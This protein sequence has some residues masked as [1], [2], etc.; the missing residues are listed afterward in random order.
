M[1]VLL[2]VLL[3][4]RFLACRRYK[5][6]GRG[7]AFL[8][9]GRACVILTCCCCCPCFS[10]PGAYKGRGRGNVFLNDLCDADVLVHV[11]DASGTTDSEGAGA[12]PGEGADPRQEVL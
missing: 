1:L 3:L 2:L 4:S 7:N 12:V 11:V 10:Y 8:N 5:G 9:T 6:R